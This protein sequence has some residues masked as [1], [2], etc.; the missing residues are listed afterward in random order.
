MTLPN[1]TLNSFSTRRPVRP[2]AAKEHKWKATRG[3]SSASRRDSSS[4]VTGSVRLNAIESLAHQVA[5]ATIPRRDL[6]EIADQKYGKA[7]DDGR[8]SE[9]KHVSN[10][11]P[12]HALP[13]GDI[14][15]HRW[16][17]FWRGFEMVA[18]F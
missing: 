3:I 14:R 18:R 9:K 15:Y 11:M 10:I 5:P 17:L 16:W 12:R 7:D 8:E 1:R 6:S 4:L 13:F 2:F